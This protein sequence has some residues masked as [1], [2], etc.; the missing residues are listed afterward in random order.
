MAYEIEVKAWIEDPAAL[1]QHLADISTAV[2]DYTKEDVYF[3]AP[4]PPATGGASAA[5]PLEYRLRRQGGQNI[6]TFKEKTIHDG[7]EV[8]REVEF[9]VSDADAFEELALRSGAKVFARKKKTGSVYA[10]P[11]A[12]VEVSHVDGLGDFV[13]I[14][15]IVEST[16]ETEHRRAQQT[17]RR[18]LSSLGVDEARIEARPYTTLLTDKEGKAL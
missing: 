1:K 3:R 13:E 12:N 16:E 9:T 17:V 7:V 11:D 14:E 6:C 5:H 15:K 18:I 8:S 4:V 2:K 10:L